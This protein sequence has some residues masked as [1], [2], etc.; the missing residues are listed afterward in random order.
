MICLPISTR[1]A[2]D[3]AVVVDHYTTVYSQHQ[4]LDISFAPKRRLGHQL[5]FGCV[6]L[7]T[8]PNRL[9]QRVGEPDAI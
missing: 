8:A 4:S 5:V 1:T 3:H 9:E 7:A 6:V 2:T